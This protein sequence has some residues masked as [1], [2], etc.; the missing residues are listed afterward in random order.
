[1]DQLVKCFSPEIEQWRN[2][3][4]SARGDNERDC[5]SGGESAGRNFLWHIIPMFC[6]VD[7]EDGIYWIHETPNHPIS[8]FI[9][10]LLPHWYVL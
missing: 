3:Q 4:S 10:G 7:F 1:M 2:E 9:K 6:M 5:V 8:M